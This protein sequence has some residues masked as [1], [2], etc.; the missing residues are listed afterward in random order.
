MNHRAIVDSTQDIA[1][2]HVSEG[3]PTGSFILAD[4]QLKGRGRVTGRSWS[5]EDSGN[6]YFSLILRPKAQKELFKLNLATCSAVVLSCR[7]FGVS[8]KGKWPNDILFEGKKLAGMLIDVEHM[9]GSM[10]AIVGVGI[11]VNSDMNQS[12]QVDI[13]T[14]SISL[15]QAANTVIE[16]EKLLASVFNNLEHLLSHDMPEVLDIYS[17]YDA[18]LGQNIVVMPKKKESDERYDAVGV[19]FTPEGFLQVKKGSGEVV[20][21]V[22]EEVSIRVA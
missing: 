17:K 16:K 1:R 4:R 20:T 12:P 21:L 7:E 9:S 22:A 3:A 18:C 10:T 2:N 13:R 5:S 19:G 8:A 11:N 14:S 6:L 15:S